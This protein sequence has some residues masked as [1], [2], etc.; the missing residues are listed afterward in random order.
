MTCEL[1]IDSSSGVIELVLSGVVSGAE[2]RK[3]TSEGIALTKDLEKTRCL[4]DASDQEETG[5]ILDLYDLPDQYAEEGLDRR[6]R[7]ALL[8]PTRDEL[9]E[10]TTFY[11][12]LC[13]N[14]GW[15]VR[16]FSDREEALDWLTED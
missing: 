16:L 15:Q 1:K 7:L 8:M 5:T 3:A 2:L 14:R 4:I 11:G 6:T 13:V 10:I 9:H 12:A